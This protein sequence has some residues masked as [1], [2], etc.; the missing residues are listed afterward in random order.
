M[1]MASQS[2][3][4]QTHG[5]GTKLAAGRMTDAKD[6]GYP[7][8]GCET[9][10]KLRRL[11]VISGLAVVLAVDAMQGD[12]QG[13][14]QMDDGLISVLFLLAAIILLGMTGP[15]GRRGRPDRTCGASGTR[16]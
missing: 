4:I 3:P 5:N 15:L 12:G 13:G 8:Q 7:V 11:A 10:R 16:R 9:C 14:G 2:P 6:R 1:A